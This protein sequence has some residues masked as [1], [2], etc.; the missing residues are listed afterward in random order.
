MSVTVGVLVKGKV[1]EVFVHYYN[2]L[3]SKNTVS[4][5]QKIRVDGLKKENQCPRYAVRDLTVAQVEEASFL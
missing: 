2:Q 4:H 5:S 1:N 3:C